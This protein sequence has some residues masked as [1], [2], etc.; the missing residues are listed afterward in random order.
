MLFI[1]RRTFLFI[2][3]GAWISGE[4]LSCQS[5]VRS[6]GGSVRSFTGYSPDG[7]PLSLF[8][9]PTC[10][11]FS[12]ILSSQNLVISTEIQLDINSGVI[13]W[14]Q[15]SIPTKRKMNERARRQLGCDYTRQNGVRWNAPSCTHSSTVAVRTLNFKFMSRKDVRLVSYAK[16]CE[17]A[18][19]KSDASYFTRDFL[20]THCRQR[21]AT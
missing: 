19:G 12:A 6:V 8:A 14:S 4:V 13:N 7:P 10:F 18:T 20:R 11:V 15:N 1:E 3:R 21:D 17:I 16:F 9:S 5:V 2:H